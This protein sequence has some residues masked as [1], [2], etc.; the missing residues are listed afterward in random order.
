KLG[1][2]SEA[3]ARATGVPVPPNKAVVGANA[4]A[5]ESG[6]HQDGVI[7]NPLTYEIMQPQAVGAGGSQ[8]VLG[9]HSGRHAVR[10]EL[11]RMGFRLPEDQFRE[12][13]RRFKAMADRREFVSKEALAHLARQVQQEAQQGE[14]AARRIAHGA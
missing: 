6:I 2:T 1:P 10:L 3:V 8:L 9:K 7:K 5:H 4:F 12:V 11:E 13:F 14:G